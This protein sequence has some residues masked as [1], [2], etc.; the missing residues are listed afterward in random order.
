MDRQPLP[1]MD[2]EQYNFP[3]EMVPECLDEANLLVMRTGGDDAF[4][5]AMGSLQSLDCGPGSPGAST[6]SV[7]WL[8]CNIQDALRSRNTAA[9]LYS[10]ED[11]FTIG[12]WLSEG[13]QYS[14]RDFLDLLPQ[15]Y[16]YNDADYIPRLTFTTDRAQFPEM[17]GR[18]LEGRFGPDVNVVEIIYSRG[19][20]A[21][22]DLE[23][24]LYLSQ[25]PAGDYKWHSMLT[26]DL[27]VP[28]P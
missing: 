19:W 28:M 5:Q 4:S 3:V 25:D 22:G 16:N 23:A 6:G 8:A 1:C 20:G 17:D 11:P 18:P 9:L 10:I 13:V 27:D 14:P 7:E 12:Y 24:L 2:V 21:E 15:L 26:G